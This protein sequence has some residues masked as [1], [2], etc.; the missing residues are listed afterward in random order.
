MSLAYTRRNKRQTGGSPQ[1]GGEC[2]SCSMPPPP[3][4]GGACACKS[5]FK[6]GSPPTGGYRATAKN[7]KYLKLYKQ[8]KS[9]GFTMLASLKA[10][11]LVPRTSRKNK[12]KKVLGPK[13][14]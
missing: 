1:T 12:G 11:G 8:G 3:Q 6:G 5:M 2:S 7:R 4:M 9:I 13:Y 10:K 14:K